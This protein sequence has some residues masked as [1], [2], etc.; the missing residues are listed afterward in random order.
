MRKYVFLSSVFIFLVL[1]SIDG[2]SQKGGISIGVV[3]I[4]TIVKS[5]PEADNADKM[6]KDVGL[7]YRDSLQVIEKE[8]MAKVDDFDKQKTMMTPDQQ[9]KEQENIRAIQVRYQ[10]FQEE[11]FGVQ[12][13]IAQMREKLLEPIR[14]KVKAAIESVAKEEKL[15]FVLDKGSSALLYSEEKSDIT[16]RVIDKMK[17]G[18]NK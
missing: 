11:K 1:F 9:K 8:Y 7:K 14:N 4:E 16:Y 12:G 5:M 18:D 13:E 3:D 15:N 17:R 10:Q 2:F 6:I